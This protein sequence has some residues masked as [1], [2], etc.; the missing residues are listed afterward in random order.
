[1]RSSGA[2]TRQGVICDPTMNMSLPNTGNRSHSS[3]E[4][5]GV[6]VLLTVLVNAF[7]MKP[8][9]FV[10]QV[11]GGLVYGFILVLLALGLSIILGSSAW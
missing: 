5:A 1:M 7:V 3:A 6:V 8:G 2:V 10:D 11:V 4:R 9:L